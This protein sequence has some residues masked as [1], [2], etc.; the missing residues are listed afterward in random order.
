M[1]AQ[2]FKSRIDTWLLIVLALSVCTTM[3]AIIMIALNEPVLLWVGLLTLLVGVGLPIWLILQTDY[4][5][6]D[7]TPLIRSGPFR[8]KVSVAAIKSI[9]PTRNPLSSPALSLDR[10]QIDYEPGKSIMVSSRDKQAF[11]D[12][13]ERQKKQVRMS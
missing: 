11:I 7:G 4:S 1:Q 3:G 12:A 9:V 8:W 10:L 2:I 5:L 13:I 6:V